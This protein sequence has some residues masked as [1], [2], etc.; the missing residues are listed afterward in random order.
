MIKAYC[1]ECGK[2]IA[3]AP[4]K[5]KYEHLYDTIPED[6]KVKLKTDEEWNLFVEEI[7]EMKRNKAI[8][9]ECP[10]CN[11]RVEFR[12]EVESCFK[13]ANDKELEKRKKLLY[14]VIMEWKHAQ[15]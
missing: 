8:R 9:I 14:D 3:S 12:N 11:K 4:K 5:K 13:F 6:K 10:Y 7:K 15:N 2:H 1:L